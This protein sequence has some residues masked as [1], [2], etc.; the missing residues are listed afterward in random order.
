MADPL[1]EFLGAARAALPPVEG[2][3][4]VPGLHEPVEVL[5]D[6]WG[7]P[8]LSAASTGRPVVRA[9][10]RPGLG[11]A[12]PDR[13]RAARG[14]RTPLGMVL[15]SHDRGRPVRADGRL[16]P[17]RRPRGPALE[18]CVAVDDAAVRRRRPGVGGRHAGPAPG[19]R[20][21]RRR[22]RPPRG[23]RDLGGRVRVPR[24]GAVGQLG[25]RAAPAAAVRTVRRPRPRG[26]C[27][28][29]RPPRSGSPRDRSPG[30]CW[31]G[32]RVR[33]ARVRTT[34]SC[35]VRGPRADG[36]S[37]P[38]TR[39]CSC[40]SRRRGSSSICERPGSRPAGWRCRSCPGS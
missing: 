33:A 39:T 2:E 13:A 31:T 19:V 35:R 29:P 28:H 9:G 25:R 4:E 23:P 38:T 37:W 21:A 11:A 3:L 22:P 30:G 20:D 12:V 18:R 36:R 7:I 17:D 5:R 16:P 1:E 24:V 40:S 14:G 27:C 10:V 26:R 15:R 6:R 34:G 8:Y 32:S